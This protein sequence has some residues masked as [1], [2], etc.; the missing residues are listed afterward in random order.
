METD[1]IG[2]DW[3][4]SSPRRCGNINRVRVENVA[5]E[6]RAAEEEKEEEEKEEGGEYR[7]DDKVIV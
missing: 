1:W 5:T 2:A 7:G 6:G 3:Q 4:S